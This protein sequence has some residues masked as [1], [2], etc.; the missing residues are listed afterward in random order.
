MEFPASDI[1]G[2]G[3][4]RTPRTATAFFLCSGNS[5]EPGNAEF[6]VVDFATFFKQ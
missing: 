5:S 6:T 2:H 1:T 4:A 3:H